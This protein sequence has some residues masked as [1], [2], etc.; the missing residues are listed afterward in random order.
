MDSYQDW[1]FTFNFLCKPV[2]NLPVL[3]ARSK[4]GWFACAKLSMTASCIC[5]SSSANE[6]LDIPMKFKNSFSPFL[7]AP[8]AILLGI[9]TAALLI[10]CASP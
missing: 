1:V 5:V 9:E 10:C 2:S 3:L 8:S 6:P 7:P 4:A